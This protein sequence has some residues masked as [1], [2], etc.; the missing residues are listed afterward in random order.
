VVLGEAF[1]LNV[2]RI[3]TAVKIPP[4]NSTYVYLL[5]RD[6]RISRFLNEPST[7][8]W[9]TVLDLRPLFEGTSETGQSGL[10]DMAFH[11][12]FAS[13]GELYV[14]Y[15]VPGDSRISYVARYSSSDGGA[16]FSQSGEI[17]L[18]V[19]RRSNYHDI[20]T[21]LFGQDGFL[22][23]GLGDDNRGSSAQDPFS[24]N[25]KI[26]RIDVDSASPYAIP[27]DNPY[28][29]GGGAPEVYAMG[30]R[31]PWRFSQDRVSGEI[32]A[33]DVGD[34]D[35]E[36]VDKIVNGGNYGWPI[37]EGAHCVAAG[38]DATGL[39]DPVYEYSHDNGCAVVGGHVYRG[40]ALPSLFG[41]YIFA[42]VCTGEIS[43]LEETDQGPV[44]DSLIASGLGILTFGEASDGEIYL[45]SANRPRLLQLVPDDS[46]APAGNFPMR[47]SDTGC[48]DPSD[49]KKVAEGVIPYDVN[50]ELWS[51]GASKRRWM[52]LPDGTQI[53]VLPD[54]DWGFPVGTVLIKEFS[55]N[56]D[57]FETRLMVRHDDGE[58]A[59]YSY[60]WNASLTDAD[61]V[62]SDGLVKQI[63][64]QLDWMYPSRAQCMECHSSAAGRS[65]GPETAQLNGPLSYPSG[66]RSNQLETLEHIG[67]FSAS[68]GAAPE[69]LPALT[70]VHDAS[71]TLSDRSR[72]YLHANCANCHRPNGPGQGPMDFRFQTAFE[73]TGTCNLD[74]EL[75][76]L[77][78]SGAKIL[79]PGDSAS[80]VVSLRMHN[81]GD[82]RM[83]PLGTQVVDAEGAAA[84]DAWID[85]LK[86]C[87]DTQPPTIDVTFGPDSI[88]SGGMSTMTFTLTNPNTVGLTGASFTNILPA[89]M[90]NASPLMIGGTCLN[91]ATDA[92]AGGSS[93]DVS[94]GDIPS[95]ASCTIT[96]DITATETGTSVP[97]AL[98][99][100]EAQDSVNGG[101]A[102]LTVIAAPPPPPPPDPPPDPPPSRKSGGGSLGVPALLLMLG[103]VACRRRFGVY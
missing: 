31:N 95:D 23:I 101:S 83:P 89:G 79:T 11:P 76:D 3:T 56:G 68:L 72:S 37:R 73:D 93:F 58:W 91:V 29:A 4:G 30:L 34:A 7:D 86:V 39:I 9:S 32:W 103:L 87:L 92:L 85:N 98:S 38:C 45:M 25:G 100:N 61:L 60:E 21:L 53:D 75:G 5:H 15:T 70:D 41:K 97:S 59:G 28:A 40:S 24:W 14:A 55:W 50:T 1:P 2:N 77:G 94:A 27:A 51:D 84:V 8:Q 99:T 65:L 102:T 6:G 80:S 26:L 35:W 66:I 17:I 46:G 69:D 18:S 81:L 20:G 19:T 82:D 90:S 22:Y 74:P 71:A 52:A 64:G 12:D 42:D 96:V 13:N 47:L 78:V 88:D 67:M 54:G 44:V 57:P 49:P 62:P 10:M 33:G 63:N 16:S 36:E 48:V 43:S